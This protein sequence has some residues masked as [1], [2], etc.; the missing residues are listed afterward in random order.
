MAYIIYSYHT[1]NNSKVP[2]EML[3]QYQMANSLNEDNEQAILVFKSEKP[4]PSTQIMPGTSIIGICMTD[5]E[6]TGP[7]PGAILASRIKE[8]LQLTV[9]ED[10]IH[11][12]SNREWLRLHESLP[13]I[14]TTDKLYDIT[15]T[16]EHNI[17]DAGTIAYITSQRDADT[18]IPITL[19]L[20]YNNNYH[21]YTNLT[22]GDSGW[23]HDN[24]GTVIY[25]GDQREL[26]EKQRN[27][28]KELSCTP[29]PGGIYKSYIYVFPFTEDNVLVDTLLLDAAISGAKVLALNPPEW[30]KDLSRSSLNIDVRTNIER[31]K[32]WTRDML[33]IESHKFADKPFIINHRIIPQ[34]EWQPGN[35][36]HQLLATISSNTVKK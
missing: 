36:S 26:S 24:K 4:Q 6:L 5:A 31:A 27:I 23:R 16:S 11:I 18:I 10:I 32:Q 22:T 8:H 3:Y 28:L 7:Q 12:I 35:L 34:T 19:S 33:H 20:L 9:S 17:G 21:A 30:V 14:Y 29:I 25:P 15:Y 13:S 1:L 2:N